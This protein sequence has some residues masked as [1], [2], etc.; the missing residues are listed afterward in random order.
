VGPGG[1][2][3]ELG[4]GGK[5]AAVALPAPR[6]TKLVLETTPSKRVPQRT[7]TAT[8]GEP[9]PAAAV[10]IIASVERGRR[11]VTLSVGPIPGNRPSTV[12]AFADPG[13]CA[14]NPP[15]MLP[16]R[17]G[18]LVSFAWVDQF[19]RLSKLRAAIRLDE[20]KAAP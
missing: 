4:Q 11:R 6:V 13:R 3:G 17:A 8:L 7:V 14:F 19:G 9:A 20:P 5:P 1:K 16:P 15:G 2:R 12:T 10:G 18:E